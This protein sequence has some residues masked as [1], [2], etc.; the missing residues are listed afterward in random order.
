MK[1]LGLGLVTLFAALGAWS[2]GV[3]AGRGV[4][5]VMGRGARKVEEEDDLAGEVDAVEVTVR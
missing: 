3:R 4:A 5:R 2:A 1:R